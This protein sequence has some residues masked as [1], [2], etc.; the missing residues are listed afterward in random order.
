MHDGYPTGILAKFD[1]SAGAAAS[2]SSSSAA[3]PAQSIAVAVEDDEQ[4]KVLWGIRDGQSG[5][6]QKRI[7]HFNQKEPLDDK[8]R[9]FL[10]P[11]DASKDAVAALT[12]AQAAGQT[13]K[14]REAN[15]IMF[16]EKRL[17]A[18]IWKLA[19]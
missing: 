2:S 8:I 19:G 1:G 3:P 15:C 13:S 14:Y 16:K 9:D 12:A 11:S 7:S 5:P 10:T 17:Q 6:G 4:V 18:D